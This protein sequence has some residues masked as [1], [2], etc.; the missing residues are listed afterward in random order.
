MREEV[1]DEW[2]SDRELIR[3]TEGRVKRRD[4][5]EGAF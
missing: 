3:P 2:T 5:G 4:E 1:E